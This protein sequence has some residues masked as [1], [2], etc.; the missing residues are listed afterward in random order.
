MKEK[1]KNNLRFCDSDESPNHVHECKF[2]NCEEG[3]KIVSGYR[4]HCSSRL[5]CSCEVHFAYW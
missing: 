1:A 4:F 2:I 5:L 3:L